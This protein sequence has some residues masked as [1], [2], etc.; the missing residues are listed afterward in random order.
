MG[1]ENTINMQEVLS[2]DCSNIIVIEVNKMNYEK[3]ARA[4]LDFHKRK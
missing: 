4:F 2:R 1:K 3:A